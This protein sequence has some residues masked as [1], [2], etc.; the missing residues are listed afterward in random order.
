MI[1]QMSGSKVG[2]RLYR[3]LWSEH[4]QCPDFCG[5]VCADTG[6]GLPHKMCIILYDGIKGVATKLH[7]SKSKNKEN[8]ALTNKKDKRG[9]VMFM[10]IA[11]RG[12]TVL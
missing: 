9:I 6:N 8:I 5:Q 11:V 12:R 7:N 1:N 10:C 3:Y 2:P 4:L